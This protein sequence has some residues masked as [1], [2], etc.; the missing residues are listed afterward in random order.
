MG[1]LTN[2]IDMGKE[3]MPLKKDEKG[4]GIIRRYRNTLHALSR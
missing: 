3:L 4:W 1:A 2:V